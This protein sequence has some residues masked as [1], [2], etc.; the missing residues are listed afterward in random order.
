MHEKMTSKL[1]NKLTLPQGLTVQPG[2]GIRYRVVLFPHAGSAEDVLALHLYNS[3]LCSDACSLE[4]QHGV[5]SFADGDG[6]L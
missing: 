1:R 2:V 3:V 6:V 4:S 5:S